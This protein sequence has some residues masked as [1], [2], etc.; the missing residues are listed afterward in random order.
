MCVQW[1]RG[2]LEGEEEGKIHLLLALNNKN[3]LPKTTS[4]QHAQQTFVRD[5]LVE[6][7]EVAALHQNIRSWI[8]CE[9]AAQALQVKCNVT[10]ITC[11]FAL[12]DPIPPAGSIKHNHLLNQDRELIWLVGQIFCNLL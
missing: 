7:K 4:A 6:K 12:F 10:K 8:E 1:Y 3:I 2:D 9:E 5:F 11:R